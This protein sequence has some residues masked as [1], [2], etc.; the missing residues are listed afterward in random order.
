MQL[1]YRHTL[2]ACY[3]GSMTQ[4]VSNNL[5]PLLFVTFQRQFQITLEQIGF[6]VTL[7]FTIQIIVD[8]LAARFADRIGYRTSIVAAHATSA[9]GL[10]GLGL[11]PR[12]FPTP[13]AGLLIAVS[14]YALGGGLLEVLVSPIVEALPTKN[15]VSSMGFLHSF[16]SIG[17][18]STI[19]LST[20]FFVCVGI[21]HWQWLP[22]LWSIMPLLNCIAFSKVPLYP[23]PGSEAPFSFRRL[24]GIKLFWLFLL[25]MI[26]SGAAEQAMAQWSS[27]FAETG[28]GVSKTM[29]DL[30]GPCLFAVLM[31]AARLI[32][33][34]FG[35][36]FSLK[37]LLLLSSLLCVASYG[38]SVLAPHPLLSLA[39]CALCGFSV[40]IMWPG[41][42]SL[43][44]KTC[45]T[46]GTAMFAFLAL[47]GDVG[48]AGGPS[49]V[50]LISDAV[51]GSSSAL[52]FGLGCAI[53][54]P[55]I[56]VISLILFGKR[57]AA[58]QQSL[59]K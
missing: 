34:K 53:L 55:L 41:V 31:G 49:L 44:A 54:F 52:K 1:H 32:Y 47:A 5:A 19:L 50:G 56:M 2:A 17:H 46:G 35:S 14:L 15:K 11:F 4:A 27:L 48:C 40:G 26:C 30:L 18:V 25:L 7:N 12:W 10:I 42:V 37:R 16:Y 23:L 3:T 21:D 59:H 28:L 20:L 43:S 24:F 9:L 36:H 38:I 6:L 45:P 29:G 13:Y 51:G 58:P 57:K 39:G 22:L 33:G 8:F